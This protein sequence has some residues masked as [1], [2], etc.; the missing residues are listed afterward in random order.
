MLKAKLADVEK[1]P[2]IVI[3]KNKMVRNTDKEQISKLLLMFLFL[4]IYF[5]Y[6]P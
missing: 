2:T 5:T 6:F 3:G 4:N 1:T